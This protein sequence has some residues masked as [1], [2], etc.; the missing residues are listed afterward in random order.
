M[1]KEDLE[2]KGGRQEG[3]GFKRRAN[4]VMY[5][6]SLA[7]MIIKYLYCKHIL[8]KDNICK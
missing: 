7:K 4:C 2:D 3:K 6:N 8:I 1:R 5:M